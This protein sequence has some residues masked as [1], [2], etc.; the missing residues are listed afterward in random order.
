[1]ESG[2]EI[3]SNGLFI[4]QNSFRANILDNSDDL[5]E[6]V[7]KFITCFDNNK[8]NVTQQEAAFSDID[9]NELVLNYTW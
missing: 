5:L 2:N 8:L 3:D 1:M 9:E 7:D 6:E 4:T